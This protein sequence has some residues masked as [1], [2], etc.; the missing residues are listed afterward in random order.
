MISFFKTL[1]EAY[2]ERP[3]L[4]IIHGLW[5]C[6]LIIWAYWLWENWQ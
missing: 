4:A 1:I 2:K 3:A 6:G 5:T